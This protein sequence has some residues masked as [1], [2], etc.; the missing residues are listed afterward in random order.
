[1]LSPRPSPRAAAAGRRIRPA[2][3]AR[4][5]PA[6][7]AAAYSCEPA[8]DVAGATRMELALASTADPLCAAKCA[9]NA[10][11]C[12]SYVVTKDLQ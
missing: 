8:A 5:A 2:R 10:S 6:L 12:T 4:G 1:M 7:S 11:W 9:S 3:R